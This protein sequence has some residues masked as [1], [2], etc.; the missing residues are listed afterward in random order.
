MADGGAKSTESYDLPGSTININ[1]NATLL[2]VLV[3]L[4]SNGSLKCTAL[5]L[6]LS[7]PVD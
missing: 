3:L 5:K 1:S 2:F 7:F 6:L 4:S